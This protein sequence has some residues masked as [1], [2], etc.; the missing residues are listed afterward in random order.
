[1]ART[2]APSPYAE[3]TGGAFAG[4]F[5]AGPQGVFYTGDQAGFRRRGGGGSSQTTLKSR[6]TSRPLPP[7]VARGK[8]SEI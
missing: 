8:F 6:R 7:A 4:T 5:F 1:M 3:P 2:G